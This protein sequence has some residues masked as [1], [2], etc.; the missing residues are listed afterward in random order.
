[1]LR[2]GSHLVGQGRDADRKMKTDGHQKDQTEEKK[3]RGEQG[4]SDQVR[5][6]N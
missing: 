5:D 3:R 2:Q 6:P 4:S 1:M